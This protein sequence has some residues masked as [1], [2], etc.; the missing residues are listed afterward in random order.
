MILTVDIGNSRIK[1]ASW[2][3]EKI[4]AR[5]V[6]SYASGEVLEVFDKLFSTLKKTSSEKPLRIYAVCVVGE[7]M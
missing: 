4:V 1:W 5:G 3:N 2:E 7:K 6:A